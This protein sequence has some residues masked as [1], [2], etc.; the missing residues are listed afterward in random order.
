VILN[1]ARLDDGWAIGEWIER[2]FVPLNSKR[3][4]LNEIGPALDK[5]QAEEDERMREADG[6]VA[7]DAVEPNAVVS[8]I[9]EREAITEDDLREAAI[10]YQALGA[11]NE[12]DRW[13]GPVRD[14][15]ASLP[16]CDSCD[17]P[18]TRANS[19]NSRWCDEHGPKSGPLE[20][21]R[22]KPMRV[23]IAMLEELR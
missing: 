23:L 6:R 1:S 5:A 17:L 14:L 16:K 3:Y 19:V 2:A 8:A 15:I 13:A 18:A 10:D 9:V 22:A 7:I 12:R 21:D 20:Y 11:F 4:T